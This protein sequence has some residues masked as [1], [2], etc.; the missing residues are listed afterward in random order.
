MR[1]T[2]DIYKNDM[3]NIGTNWVA[4]ILIGG[5]IILP[6]LYAWLNIEASWDPYSQTDQIPIGIV[7]EDTGASVRDENIHV[8]DEIVNHLKDNDSMDWQITDYDDAMEKIEYGDFFAVIV[9]PEDFSS[10]LSTVIKAEPEKAQVEYYVNEKINAISPKITDKGAS[11][12]VEEVSSSFI[13][14]VNG[15]IFEVFNDIGLEIEQELPDIKQFEEYI[16]TL[17]DELPEINELLNDTI[18]DAAD[19]DDII[20]KAQD[21]I[22]EAEDMTEEGLETID[23]T[24]EFLNEAEDRLTE[25]APKIEED[26]VRVQQ[27]ASDVNAFIE[28]IQDVDIDFSRGEEIQTEMNENIGKGIEKIESIETVLVQLREQI[29]DP[30]E[31]LAERIAENLSEQL[32]EEVDEELTEQLNK[33]LTEQLNQEL[34]NDINTE[35]IDEALDK[36]GNLKED[37]GNVQDRADEITEFVAEKEGDVD[38]MLTDLASL[39]EDTSTKIDGFVQEY[40]ETIEPKVFE[41]VDNAKSTLAS[42]REILVE[43]QDTIPEVEDILSRTSENI[44]K[45]ETSLEAV[46]DEFPFVNTKVN[47][48]A[49]RIRDIQDEADINEIIELLKNDPEKERSFFE[50]PVKLQ[51]NKIFPVENYGTGMTP[52]YSVLAIWVGCILL[53]SL[54]A[55]DVSNSEQYTDRQIYFGRYFTFITIGI[56]QSLIITIGDLTIIG[57]DVSAP[58]LFVLFGLFISIV[59]MSIVYT[60]VSVFGDV[61]KAI[62]IVLLVLQISGSGGTYPVVLLPEFFQMINPF[63]PF[64]YAVDLMREAVGGIVWELVIKDLIFLTVSGAIFVLFGAI[65]KKR[66]NKHTN[67]LLKKSKESGLFH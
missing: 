35:T 32:G 39:T 49:D 11:V 13:S 16:F 14:N 17:E 31:N 56:L 58:F 7:N 43:I 61:G 36:L 64:T 46:R 8:G 21:L 52:F 67:K 60:V 18:D 19:A 62:A 27:I 59:F 29:E 5:L 12:L 66:V 10:N 3:K 23:E 4:L 30:D 22:P 50:E 47:E 57:V 24:T 1:K 25:M 28:T 37:L 34:A 38:D 26:L 2:W 53:I 44:G 55:V 20:T 51:E 42:A 41:E 54:L 48:V 45:G 33:E 40:K 15:I 6:S 65:F 63:L 9:I